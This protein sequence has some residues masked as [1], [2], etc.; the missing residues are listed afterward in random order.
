MPRNPMKA[1]ARR[2]ALAGR[3][4]SA[5]VVA[6]TALALAA[7]VAAPVRADVPSGQGA[8]ATSRPTV[9]VT[10]ANADQAATA[11]HR[12]GGQV[13][14][15]LPIA[16]SV[17]A[18]MPPGAELNADLVVTPDRTVSFTSFNESLAAPAVT[19]RQTLG[20]RTDQSSGRG[21]TVAL[22]DTGVADVPDLAGRTRHI[23]VTG[24][25]V[26][27]GYGHGTFLAGLIAGSGHQSGGLYRGIAPGASIL[28]VKVA[29]NDGMTSLSMV[30]RGLQAV[31]D[32]PEDR[33]PQVLNLSLSSGSPLP[34]QVDP[35][36]Q[37]LRALWFGGVAVVVAAGNDGPAV[38]TVTTPGN[39]PTLLTAGGLDELGTAIRS[40]DAVA[41]WSSRGRTTQNVDKPDIVAPGAHLVGLRSPGSIIDQ[42]HPDSRVGEAYF[43][44]SGTSMSAAVVSG[45]IADILETAPQLQPDQ[46]KQL[47]ES[48]AYRAGALKKPDGA[49][50]GG[51]DLGTALEVAASGR[52]NKLKVRSIPTAPGSVAGWQAL[53]DAL[54]R[55]DRSAAQDAWDKLGPSAR[56]WAA[57]SWAA[58]DVAA[59]SWA[60]RSWAARS[61]ADTGTDEQEWAARSWAARSWAGEDWAARSW[62]G[63][64]WLARSWAGDE[65]AARSWASDAWGARSWAALWR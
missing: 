39:D 44:G 11:V 32:L 55:G 36:N 65:W 35:L 26:G 9:I 15:R 59:R 20:V 60:A 58:L 46:V 52:V 31:A 37:A 63:D 62:A 61:W 51:V 50:S 5:L 25:G 27:D 13:I 42:E 29:G 16:K 33:R 30:L 38:G 54:A 48:T 1:T 24:Q 57:R 22:V 21:V 53:S 17:A 28:D 47:L 4:A 3:P 6:G 45:A 2:R 41:D 43:R 19:M 34:Y 12:A 49:G 14:A 64:N 23:D 7:A 56:S 8:A 40:D 18:I 10:G